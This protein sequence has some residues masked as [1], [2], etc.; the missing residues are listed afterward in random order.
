MTPLRALA[1][2]LMLSSAFN[3]AREPQQSPLGILTVDKLA[4]FRSDCSQ[5]LQDDPVCGAQ[6]WTRDCDAHFRS[7]AVGVM[8]SK[9]EDWATT[10]TRKIGCSAE[11]WSLWTDRLG[12]VIAI[13]ADDAP[14]QD[15]SN[16]TL[17]LRDLVTRH[18]GEATWKLI[19]GRIS[20]EDVAH[21]SDWN[22]WLQPVAPVVVSEPGKPPRVRSAD[23]NDRR[24]MSC[25]E[26]MLHK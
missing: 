17:R 21:A 18:W 9:S 26:F 11:G 13:C 6:P 5:S 15:P 3:C 14:G 4:S 20:L 24:Q 10:A 22:T 16:A 7:V 8:P 23:P 1:L 12:R 25:V 19:F 2:T